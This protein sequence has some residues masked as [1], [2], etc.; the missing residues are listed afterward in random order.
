MK[1][2]GLLGT[3]YTMEQDFYRERLAREFGLEVLIPDEADRQ[4][5]HQVIFSELCVG[6]SLDASRQLYRDIIQ[7]L[8]ARGAEGI[9][10]G[11]TE[12]MLLISETDSPVP[13]FDT[14]ALHVAAAL[15]AAMAV[16]SIS[17]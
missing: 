17:A 2:V 1:R 4:S 14:T 15:D 3:L 11:C 6:Q 7:R 12:I 16:D 8:V 10:L 13:L 5:V 9:I